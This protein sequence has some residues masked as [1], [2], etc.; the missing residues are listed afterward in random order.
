M[1][2][3]SCVKLIIKMIVELRVHS[4]NETSVIITPLCPN[5]SDFYS[6]IKNKE[7]KQNFL[8]TVEVDQLCLSYSKTKNT[9]ITA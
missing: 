4:K 3:C 6:S 8:Y 2:M 5:Q 7:V 9:T 1:A